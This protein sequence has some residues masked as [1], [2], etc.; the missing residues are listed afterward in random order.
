MIT[1]ICIALFPV[2]V[3]SFTQWSISV[4]DKEISKQAEYSFSLTLSK[5]VTTSSYIR[6]IFPSDF[7]SVLLSSITCKG[8]YNVISQPT[9]SISGLEIQ[10]KN[11]FS[12]S[13]ASGSII[14][15]SL[16]SVT[17]LGI[18]I[19]SK[20]FTVKTLDSSGLT[21]ESQSSGLTVTYTG[22]PLKSF[23]ITPLSLI[24]G[25]LSVWTLSSFLDIELPS[26]GNITIL[27]PPWN[28]N[29]SPKSSQ[30]KSFFPGALSCD[31]EYLG[32]N[33][34]SSCSA[35]VNTLIIYP[36]ITLLGD[37]K[38]F[39]SS[40]LIPPSL[41]SV[42]QINITIYKTQGL[43]QYYT[44]SQISAYKSCT[45]SPVLSLSD[46]SLSSSADYTLS[47]STCNPVS[48]SS[49]LRI[50]I[51]SEISPKITSILGLFGFDTLLPTYTLSSQ[52]LTITKIFVSYKDP[53]TYLS[54]RIS[55][56]INPSSPLPT[57][58]FKIYI[59]TDTYLSDNCE[60]GLQV[61]VASG[62]MKTVT[63]VPSN[64]QVG[65]NN[66]YV[67]MFEADEDIPVGSAVKIEFP[68]EIYIPDCEDTKLSMFTEISESAVYN[69]KDNTLYMTE[70]FS[71]SLSK[72]FQFTIENITNAQS[73]KPTSTFL[74][75]I[76]L[77]SS[78]SHVLF[79]DSAYTLTMTPANFSSV[80][81][82]GTSQVTG[83]I[84]TYKFTTQGFI[85]KGQYFIIEFLDGLI[86]TV[87]TSK[88]F[89]LEGFSSTDICECTEKSIKILT[90][91]EI[92]ENA[93][94]EIGNI[95]NPPSTKPISILVKTTTLDNFLILTSY[96][97]IQMLE[98]HNF[99]IANLVLSTYKIDTISTYTFT[100]SLFNPIPSSA[101]ILI[102]TQVDFSQAYCLAPF[103]CKFIE[104]FYIYPNQDSNNIEA[105]VYGVINPMST[106]P[107]IIIIKTCDE[108]CYDS[109]EITI[110]ITELGLINNIII[111]ASTEIVNENSVLEISFQFEHKENID[112]FSL[113]FP[114]DFSNIKLSEIVM[115][116]TFYLPYN[117]A[118]S[119]TL[120]TI[121]PSYSGDY[122]ISITSYEQNY[123]V[124]F[125]LYT[126]TI[127]CSNPC[128]QCSIT[129]S[130]CISCS[131]PTPYLVSST[132]LSSCPPS[133]IDIGNYI[134]SDCQTHCSSCS[135]PSKCLICS[136][137]YVLYNDL[138]LD[139]CPQSTYNSSSNCLS[140]ST[141]CLSCISTPTTCTSCP[142]GKILYKSSCVNTCE[143][144]LINNICYDCSDN[145]ATCKDNADFCTSCKDE[146]ILYKQTCYDECP[147]GSMIMG[148]SCESCYSPC[149]TCSK[150]LSVCDSCYEGSQVISDQCVSICQSGYYYDLGI[151]VKC[152]D[153]CL[154]CQGQADYCLSCKEGFA[155][156]GS[157]VEVC[158]EKVSIQA[159]SSCY[160][161]ISS[162]ETCSFTIDNCLSC[163]QNL[164]LY[165]SQCLNSCPS[166]YFPIN[167]LCYTCPNNCLFCN[168]TSC[169]LCENSY[170]LYS[171]FCIESCPLSTLIFGSL[172]INCNP[173]CLTCGNSTEICTSCSNNTYLHMDNCFSECPTGY[174]SDENMCLPV[175]CGLHCTEK[176][177]QN[178]VCDSVCNYKNCSYDNNICIH[179]TESLQIKKDP[180]SFTIMTV[181][182][183]AAG[184]TAAFFTAGSALSVAGSFSGVLE[185]TGW[186]AL[187]SEISKS[188]TLHQRKL[189][190]STPE[191]STSFTI[192]IVILI[193]RYFINFCFLYNYF[194]IRHSDTK[195]IDWTLRNTKMWKLTVFISAFTSYNTIQI[196]ICKMFQFEGF[197]AK[198]EKILDFYKL[199][200]ITGIADLVIVSIPAVCSC[201][202]IL[203]MYSK[204]TF[205]FII[206]LDV[207]I[208]TVIA[209]IIEILSLVYLVKDMRKKKNSALMVSVAVPTAFEDLDM[210]SEN[211]SK[212]GYEERYQIIKQY[213]NNLRKFERLN[214]KKPLTKC[215]SLEY[216]ED[217]EDSSP[218]SQSF[219][220][221][222]RNLP[223]KIQAF[224]LQDEE[225][226][227]QVEDEY[228]NEISDKLSLSSIEIE[229]PGLYENF[230]FI[231][232]DED[233]YEI[234]RVKCK[235]LPSVLTLRKSFRS[236]VVVDEDNNPVDGA[237]FD[238]ENMEIVEVLNDMPSIGIFRNRRTGG[239]VR[240][241]RSFS[242]AQVVRDRRVLT[243]KQ[244]FWLNSKRDL[245][246][247]SGVK[248]G[249]PLY[250][251]FDDP[252]ILNPIEKLS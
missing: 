140:C 102:D 20:S 19:T 164:Y 197:N 7:D 170:F 21:L 25:E 243:G 238:Y 114:N 212:T 221:D 22:K 181:G 89:I 119:V 92:T 231:E 179:Y 47:F 44:N 160:P 237:D 184:T 39:L 52:I 42:S 224:E 166:G 174:A 196:I 34:S 17:N 127:G 145:C 30:E 251:K 163:P 168:Q 70:A 232:I 233:D 55:T 188:T 220:N 49:Q 67:F 130:N 65:K 107:D 24:A 137:P 139:T 72:S 86:L 134:C 101:Y 5:A 48:S 216:P 125:G 63:I 153:N 156:S 225:N 54:F 1:K 161:C 230:E 200:F 209:T 162:C 110:Q 93:S 190:S 15:F 77:D 250:W 128:T 187:L 244:E 109:S 186:V 99:S 111:A 199:L 2:L 40:G 182:T 50:I 178:N 223:M 202:Y 123:K 150:G 61:L 205:V 176:L 95:K 217:R 158:P 83:D 175:V 43:I 10:I 74:I 242:D 131:S 227:D 172:C 215:K 82:Q 59:E 115:E 100:L 96:F 27:F 159:S 45:L 235:D 35:T 167:G 136:S 94:F 246:E 218:I 155:Y 29:F 126:F 11:P 79:Q 16:L 57:S 124:D 239:V 149:K 195:H 98:L 236:G 229:V 76:Y 41:K 69:V 151:C 87:T 144:L 129:G 64:Y 117:D 185:W 58:S 240:V 28:I 106:K 211:S 56:L 38:V 219:T 234:I 6:L 198:F 207:F 31:I 103:T 9:S 71:V 191:I 122:E 165:E 247:K 88:C 108:F 104:K 120:E 148:F 141:S 173:S 112:S 208:V 51:P 222:L 201:I 193:L 84:T 53:G 135:S 90:S 73:S 154:E 226:K 133:Q 66:N 36:S 194:V 192:I 177:L 249:H 12:T 228:E 68:D 138:C 180:M 33:T 214:I 14:V 3:L 75:Q 142:Q 105:L 37:F 60:D 13:L 32:V 146:M 78:F 210:T 245:I 26:T 169:L 147:D 80:S 4:T 203:S 241:L 121:L 62:N 18:A 81:I 132:C 204:G 85:G 171:G 213:L 113:S 116:N 252:R 143:Y 91:S 46:E 206:A 189:L 8:I 23:S 152:A 118:N 97:T 248:P 157:C 183:T